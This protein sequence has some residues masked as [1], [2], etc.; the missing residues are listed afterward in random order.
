MDNA[1]R[2]PQPHSHLATHQRHLRTFASR[3]AQHFESGAAPPLAPEP[4]AGLEP[5]RPGPPSS[6]CNGVG[7]V[8]PCA[9]GSDPIGSRRLPR[10]KSRWITAE[11]TSEKFARKYGGL[12]GRGRTYL[13]H[14]QLAPEI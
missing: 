11:Q 9:D 6:P 10:M 8:L 1:S 14:Q 13:G 12:R 7:I 5:N 2:C 4:A 3:F